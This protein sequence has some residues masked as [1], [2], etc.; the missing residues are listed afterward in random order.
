[1]HLHYPSDDRLRSKAGLMGIFSMER[2]TPV[3]HV[4]FS[5]LRNI[6]LLKTEDPPALDGR[7]CSKLIANHENALYAVLKGFIETEVQRN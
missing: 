4:L 2:L 3:C 7:S 5:Y 6:L 1:M